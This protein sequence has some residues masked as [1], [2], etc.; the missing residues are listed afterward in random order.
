M[1]DPQTAIEPSGAPGPV[2]W[3]AL[4]ALFLA[5]VVGFSIIQPLGRTPDEVA[6]VQYVRFLAENYRLPVFAP[7][8]GGEGGYQAQHPPLYYAVMA[9]AYEATEGLEERWRWHILRWLT[10]L[11]VGGGGFLV[12]RAIFLRIW[13]DAR[14]IALTGTAATMLMPLTI[15]YACHVNPDG[16]AFLVVT[17]ALYLSLLTAR[18]APSV[19]RAI[20][21]GLTIG[22]AS[23]I[24]ISALIAVVPAVIA[25]A[26]LA[27]GDRPRGW[28][29]D[30][31]ITVGVALAMGVWWYVR[32]IIY[33]GSPFIHTTAPYGSALENALASGNF[34]FLAWLTIKN[35][36]LSTWIQRGWL[37]GGPAEWAFYGVIG[38]LLLAAV[39]GWILRSRDAEEH[40]EMPATR[41]QGAMMA[42]AL[43]AAVLL[44]QQSAFWLSDVEFNAGGRYVLMAMAGMLHLMITGWSTLVTR[45]TLV[46]IFAC[47]AAALVVVDL[48]SAW[49]IVSVLNPRHAA[50][51]QLFHFPPG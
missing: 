15:L 18:N 2:A 1:T 3:T 50:G 46:I 19:S 6:H 12:C 47:F 24:K 26:Y 27:R 8:G 32:N 49:H 33:Y 35:T 40:G 44:G 30:V 38:V 16:P 43:I 14:W 7:A 22:A 5:L 39:V 37:P 21:L 23:L 28:L 9:L 4:G 25:W 20:L 29:R 48:L 34:G 36:F 13:P 51:W 31:G 11:L 17:I 41:R 10:A 45:R 42:A